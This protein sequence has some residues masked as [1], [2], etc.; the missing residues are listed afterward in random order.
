MLLM[1]SLPFEVG[2]FVLLSWLKVMI[3][4]MLTSRSV[5][6]YNHHN[7]DEQEE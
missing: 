1:R 5:P 6:L 4:S 7:S 3:G 2:C